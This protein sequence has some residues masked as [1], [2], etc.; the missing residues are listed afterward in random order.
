MLT[1]KIKC[2]MI[3]IGDNT[4]NKQS[5]SLEIA[6]IIL[7][8][9]RASD[10]SALM[11]WGASRFVSLEEEKIGDLFSMGGIK[12]NVRGMKYTG[13]VVVRLMANDTYRLEVG[14]PYKKEFR[15]KKLMEEVY[16]DELMD[17]IDEAVER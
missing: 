9:I 13:T 17:M 14:R 10:R 7:G 5:R 16:C 8:Q 15:V 3:F 12:F 11:A 2:G 1:A 6:N 4:M